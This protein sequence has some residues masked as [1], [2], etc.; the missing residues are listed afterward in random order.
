[1][2]RFFENAKRKAI[3]VGFNSMKKLGKTPPPKTVIWECTLECNMKCAH[4]GSYSDKAKPNELTKKEILGILKELSNYGIERFVLTGGEPLLRKDIFEILQKAKE[5]GIKTGF[6]TNAY[7]ISE[8]NVGKIVKVADSIQVSVDSKKETHDSFRKTKGAFDRAINAIK[9]LKKNGCKQVCMTSTIG[10]FNLNELEELYSLAKEN[11]D[12]WRVGTVMPIGRSSKNDLLFLTGK[13]LKQ[14][15]DFVVEK[16]RGKFPILLG[17]N[18]GYLGSYDKKI[19]KNDFFFCGIGILSCCIGS[20][21][22]IRG[23]P[24]LPPN[25]EFIVGDLRKK[26]FK[27]IW[28]NSFENYRDEN[29]SMLPRECLECKDLSLCRGGCQVMRLKGLHCTPKRLEQSKA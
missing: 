28:E 4:C 14:L 16:M 1:M 24:E 23:C 8:E 20:D 2:I 26:P 10:P 21:G 11:A 5:L 3:L 19:H 6:S 27:E 25:E 29:Y 12:L 15:L 22:K 7:F 13:Q 9:L 17:E 18:L